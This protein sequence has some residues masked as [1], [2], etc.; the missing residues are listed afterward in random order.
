MHIHTISIYYHIMYY[1]D[2]FVYCFNH[3]HF[4]DN[5]DYNYVCLKPLSVLRK[6]ILEIHQK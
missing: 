6:N 2:C 5:K 4:K 1:F 3:V